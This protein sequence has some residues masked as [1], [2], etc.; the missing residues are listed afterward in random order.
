MAFEGPEH[1]ADGLNTVDGIVDQGFVADTD[2]SRKLQLSL[3]FGSTPR[4]DPEELSEGATTTTTRTLCDVR[5][6]RYRCPPQLRRETKSLGIGETHSQ[7]IDVGDEPAASLP[8]LQPSMIMHPRQLPEMTNDWNP[9]DR[10]YHRFRYSVPSTQYAV[11]LRKVRYNL[12][13]LVRRPHAGH[14]DP[15]C[16]VGR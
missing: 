8:D 11:P 5:R 6:D 4:S 16:P 1:L 7:F 2:V 9:R 13:S 3:R 12:T 14:G 15:W 10:R